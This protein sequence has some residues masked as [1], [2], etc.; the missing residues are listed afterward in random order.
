[1][2]DGHIVTVIVPSIGRPTLARTQ[3]ALASQ[4]RPADEIIVAPDPDRHGAGWARNQAI[5]QA[6]GDLIAFTDDD[7]EPPPDWLERLIDA[8]D[9]HGAAVAGGTLDE[10]DPF[11]REVRRRR[12]L[13]TTTHVDTGG[14]VGNGGNIMYRREWLLRMETGDGEFFKPCFGPYGS[15]DAELMWR[16][17]VLGAK[18]VFV[19]N[20]VL[21]N[22]RMTR[23]A[24]LKMKWRRGVG[25]AMLSRIQKASGLRDPAPRGMILGKSG[26]A[27]WLG[28][29]KALWLK[30]VGPF[31][32]QG[33]LSVRDF[34]VYW[35]GEKIQGAAFVWT[36][37]TWRIPQGKP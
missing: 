24:Y 3:A 10:P 29:M 30:G 11:L 33:F 14:F 28:W 12:S 35:I 13:P 9:R 20:P 21:H 26:K 6:K 32:R 36:S 2:L 8:I 37:R 18:G 15:E 17:R 4:T 23:T 7:C 16:L 22:K 1:M 5:R 27:K 34:W 25:T 19:A 31:G